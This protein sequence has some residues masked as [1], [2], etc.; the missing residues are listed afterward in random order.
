MVMVGARV[1]IMI[2]VTVR[3]KVR[4]RLSIRVIGVTIKGPRFIAFKYCLEVCA[5]NC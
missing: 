1:R 2:V 3:E 5:A 4:V